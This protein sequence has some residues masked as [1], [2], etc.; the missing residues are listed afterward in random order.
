MEKWIEA[1]GEN[2]GEPISIPD[3]GVA[4]KTRDEGAVLLRRVRH[5]GMRKARDRIYLMK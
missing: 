4:S 3:Q 1:R 5:Q 2:A